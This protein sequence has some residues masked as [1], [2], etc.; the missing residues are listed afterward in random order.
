MTISKIPLYLIWLLAC[1]QNVAA[2]GGVGMEDDKCIITIGFLKAHFTGYQ[3]KTNGTEEFCE[4]IPE[5]A[6][7]VFVIE[8][9]HDFLKKMQVDFRIIKDVFLI[10]K[11]NLLWK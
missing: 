7:S 8:Y 10:S 6:R 2:H 9:L 11:E 1:S 5:V 4:D 3:P